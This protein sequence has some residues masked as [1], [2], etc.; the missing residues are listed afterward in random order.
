M[1]VFKTE[2]AEA[3]I[4][5]LTGTVGVGSEGRSVG[6]SSSVDGRSEC[7]PMGTNGR[8]RVPLLGMGL[9]PRESQTMLYT[10]IFSTSH[11][12]LV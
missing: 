3:V 6:E 10:S 7:R 11:N 8:R 5:E 4:S 9:I 2:V 1:G 12:C